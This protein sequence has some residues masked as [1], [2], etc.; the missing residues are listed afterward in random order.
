MKKIDYKEYSRLRSIARKRIERAAAQGLMPLVKLPTVAELK[1]ADDPGA[2]MIQIQRFLES[3]GSGI[4]GIKAGAAPFRLE[5]P[6]VPKVSKLTEEEKK[7]RKRKSNRRYR[8]RKA[9]EKEAKN[10]VKKN[11]YLSYLKALETVRKAWAKSSDVRKQELATYI[12]NLTGREAK[13]F[14]AYMDYR[15]SQADYKQRYII[16]TII[17][18]YAE[19]RKNGVS[20][21][22]IQ[23]DF[24]KFIA[25]QKRLWKDKEDTNKFGVDIEFLERVWKK[26]VKKGKKK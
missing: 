8:A 25:D 26:Y 4:Q 7:Q 21:T 6:P 2:Y 19:L 16:S 24:E 18:D 9:V 23:K 13:Q 5:L 12:G 22:D 14:V 3:P 1:K 11:T 20:S 10:E 17:E 15:F